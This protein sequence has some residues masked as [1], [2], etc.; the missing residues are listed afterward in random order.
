MLFYIYL[1]ITAVLC[2][3]TLWQLVKSKS[4]PTAICLG[5][6]AIPLILRTLLIK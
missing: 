2:V 6:V 1:A 3:L 4:I 5:I